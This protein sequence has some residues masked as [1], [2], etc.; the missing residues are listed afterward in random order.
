MRARYI[1]KA[2]MVAVAAAVAG[3]LLMALSPG[4]GVVAS[5][6][7]EV[8]SEVPTV[9]DVEQICRSTTMPDDRLDYVPQIR[10]Q[11]SVQEDLSPSGG[12]ACYVLSYWTFV[13]L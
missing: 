5:S 8:N 3:A 9:Y 11:A 10:E 1:S 6:R 7:D 13:A 2:R 12:F 4:R